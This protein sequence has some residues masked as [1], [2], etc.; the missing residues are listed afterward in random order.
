MSSV[1]HFSSTVVSVSQMSDT[2]ANYRVITKDNKII[3]VN[4]KYLEKQLSGMGLGGMKPQFALPGST[5]VY[6]E[7]H[8]KEGDVLLNNKLEEAPELGKAT[9]NWVNTVNTTFVASENL[10]GKAQDIYLKEEAKA[11]FKSALGINKPAKPVKKAEDVI[12]EVL[13]D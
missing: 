2:K 10:V 8:Y 3:Y 13:V 6:S 9:K 5:I 11:A 1:K 4:P 12:N 7:V